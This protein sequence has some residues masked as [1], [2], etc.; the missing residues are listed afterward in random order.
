VTLLYRLLNAMLS[1]GTVLIASMFCGVMVTL[2]NIFVNSLLVPVVE[3]L[4]RFGV[5]EA[6]IVVSNPID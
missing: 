2:F 4:R 3:L 6:S 5:S 1:V